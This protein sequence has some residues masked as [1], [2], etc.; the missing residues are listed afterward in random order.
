M[1]L[2]RIAWIV[3]V[4]V[5]LLGSILLFIAGYQGYGALAIAVGAA[6]GTNIPRA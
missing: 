1:S 2:D 5:C 3:T 4:A 6:A